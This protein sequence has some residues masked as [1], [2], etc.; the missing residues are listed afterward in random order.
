[1][2]IVNDTDVGINLQS[3]HVIG[4]AFEVDTILSDKRQMLL[5]IKRNA[6]LCQK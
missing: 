4:S 2:Q 6:V 5:L 3:N 1:M